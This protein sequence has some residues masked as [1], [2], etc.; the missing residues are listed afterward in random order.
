MGFEL[1]YEPRR[2][3][4]KTPVFIFRF[5]QSSPFKEQQRLINGLPT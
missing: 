5:F 2:T 4:C 1:K 3:S